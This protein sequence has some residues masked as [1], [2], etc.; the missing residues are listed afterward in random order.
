VSGLGAQRFC[1]ATP[2]G[3]VGNRRV[4]EIEREGGIIPITHPRGPKPQCQT[5]P[6]D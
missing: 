3:G 1:A 6:T 4:E 5:L 2:N